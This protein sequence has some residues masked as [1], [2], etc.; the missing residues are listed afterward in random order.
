M[1]LD[2]NFIQDYF[3]AVFQ[4]RTDMQIDV[5]KEKNDAL[6][7]HGRARFGAGFTNFRFAAVGGMSSGTQLIG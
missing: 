7:Y 3:A 6:T 4:D 1:M 5:F 2:T